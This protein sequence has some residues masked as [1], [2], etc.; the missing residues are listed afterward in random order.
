MFYYL[1]II[2]YHLKREKMGAQCCKQPEGVAIEETKFT[3][4]GQK[5]DQEAVEQ[6]LPDDAALNNNEYKA[7]Y[8]VYANPIYQTVD[9]K[10]N[11]L[12]TGVDSNVYNQYFQTSQQEVANQQLNVQQNEQQA[13][14]DQQVEQTN[15]VKET[16]KAEVNESRNDVEQTQQLKNTNTQ[17]NLT[18]TNNENLV[19]QPVQVINNILPVKYI[20]TTVA[21]EN[22]LEPVTQPISYSNNVVV[23]SQNATT[24]KQTNLQ[25]SQNENTQKLQTAQNV[26]NVQNV[27]YANTN[28]QNVQNVQE[29]QYAP[30][31]VQNV[32]NIQSVQDIQYAPANV[33]NVQ[34]YVTNDIN[35]FNINENLGYGGVAYNTGNAQASGYSYQYAVPDNG[36][37]YVGASSYAQPVTGSVQS[38]HYSTSYQLPTVTSQTKTTTNTNYVSYSAAGVGY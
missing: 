28:V 18:A 10:G 19:Y 7:E 9:E 16:N 6:K 30:T 1:N 11:L 4:L 5:N 8:V 14:T 3:T 29:V 23:N 12:S 37:N 25:I 22:V 13:V 32:Q 20:G 38:Y 36:V 26:Q 35:Q 2:F 17:E 15:A 33:Q 21:K 31:N 27:Q 34:T 24:E